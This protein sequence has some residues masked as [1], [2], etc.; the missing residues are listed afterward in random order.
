MAGKR[1]VEIFTA[2]CICCQDAVN[3]VTRIACDSCHIEIRDMRQDSTIQRARE[4]GVR[5]V[6]SMAIDGVL[7][8]CCAGGI[9]EQ[10]LRSAGIGSC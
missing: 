4:L 10:A 6:P 8:P 3:L 5:C 7:A 2:G 1:K 9:D